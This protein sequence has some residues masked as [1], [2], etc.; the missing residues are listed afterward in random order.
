MLHAHFASLS[1]RVF[2]SKFKSK[3][4]HLLERPVAQK[5]VILTVEVPTQSLAETRVGNTWR[6]RQ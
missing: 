2:G 5:R 4:T 3:A 6:I 1:N